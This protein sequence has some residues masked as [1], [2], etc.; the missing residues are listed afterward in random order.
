MTAELTLDPA[1]GEI[2][3]TCPEM[4]VEDTQNA[5]N[6]A[7]TAFQSFR[8]TSPVFRQKLLL[9]FNQLFEN[10]VKDLAR[11]IV[12]ENGKSW[13]DAL[14]EATYAASY[15][16]WFAGEALRTNGETI[17]CSLPG[18]RNFTIKQPIGV[19]ALLVP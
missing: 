10:N 6:T 18:T 12:W 5:V 15:V 16:S 9:K 4:T 19:C 14:A 13:T 8:H 2:I 7:Y 11:L 3:G 17:P 1:T